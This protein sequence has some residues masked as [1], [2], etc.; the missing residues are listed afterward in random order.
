MNQKFV[1]ELIET[2]K[3][4]VYLKRLILQQVPFSDEAFAGLLE[5]LTL[6]MRNM[7][8]LDVSLNGFRSQKMAELLETLSKNRRL[9]LWI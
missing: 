1:A 4:N 7:K 9:K 6:A 2:L 5:F 8:K 3:G